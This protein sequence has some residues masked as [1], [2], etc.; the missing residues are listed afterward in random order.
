M[1]FSSSTRRK[2]ESLFDNAHDTF[3]RTVTAYKDA[4]NTVTL[5]TPQY[6][7]IYGTAGRFPLSTSKTVV[8][9]TFTARIR[10]IKNTEE[11]LEKAETSK[12]NSQFKL[13]LPEGTVRI[14]VASDGKVFIQDAKRIDLD[15]KRY[16]LLN[17]SFPELVSTY[18]PKYF[19]F[20]LAPIDE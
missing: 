5:T 17:D 14:K 9:S 6:N 3:G 1:W 16:R 4:E 20:Y 10:Y 15:G 8:S 7:S 19:A 18:T 12:T 11:N 2:I 13:S